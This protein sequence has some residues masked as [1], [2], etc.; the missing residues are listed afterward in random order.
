MLISTSTFGNPILG[1][2]ISNPPPIFGAFISTST[3]GN[4]IFGPLIYQD[5]FSK[6]YEGRNN[7]RNYNYFRSKIQKS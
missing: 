3:F 7:L 4:P 6:Y 1:P 2:L 5:V